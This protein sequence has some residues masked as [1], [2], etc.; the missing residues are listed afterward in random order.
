MSQNRLYVIPPITASILS[1]SNAGRINSPVIPVTLGVD[2]KGIEQTLDFACGRNTFIAGNK[3]SDRNSML[4]HIVG[5]VTQNK[6]ASDVKMILVS[7]GNSRL[8]EFSNNPHVLLPT[9]ESEDTAL[10]VLDYLYDENVRRYELIAK[11]TDE[12]ILGYNKKVGPKKRVPFLICIID[13]VAGLINHKRT[14]F[15]RKIYQLSGFSWRTGVMLVFATSDVSS[16]SIS[17]QFISSFTRRISFRLQDANQSRLFLES[18]G[19]ETLGKDDLFLFE[20]YKGGK[21]MK[22][23]SS[24]MQGGEKQ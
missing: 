24:F 2:A 4:E 20:G 18:E 21:T 15:K 22:I 5:S 6:I 7:L 10:K 8:R 16:E 23:K 14:E 1:L 19:A 17:E 12:W 3:E 9:I 11:K 13:D